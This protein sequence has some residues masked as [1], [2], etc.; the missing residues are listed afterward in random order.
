MYD[1]VHEIYCFD[2]HC[3]IENS[4]ISLVFVS[5]ITFLVL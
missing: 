4:G 1:K 2:L 3:A 5:T